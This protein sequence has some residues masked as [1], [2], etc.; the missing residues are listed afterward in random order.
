MVIYKSNYV[1]YFYVIKNYEV[2]KKSS[3]NI[4]IKVMLQ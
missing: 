4:K 3:L 2:N 1:P